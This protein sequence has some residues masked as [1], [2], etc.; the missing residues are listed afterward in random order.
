MAHTP[1]PGPWRVTHDLRDDDEAVCDLVNNTWVIKPTHARLGSWH[2]DAQ[3][4]AAAPDMLEALRSV[5]FAMGEM[6]MR[7]HGVHAQVLA[8]IAKA[9]GSAA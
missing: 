8:A 9:T 4:I 1:T 7:C 6:G 2:A 5:E 3:L